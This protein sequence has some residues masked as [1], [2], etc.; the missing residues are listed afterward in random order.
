[1]KSQKTAAATSNP[2]VIKLP[3]DLGTSRS[4][5]LFAYVLD[6]NGKVIETTPFKEGSA[7]L[8][9]S[10]RKTVKGR[11]ISSGSHFP[12][13]YSGIQNRRLRDDAGGSLPSLC[14]LQQEQ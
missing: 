4:K 1:M 7:E 10:G 3:G 11:P 13:E 12:P 14:Q 8:T 5:E 6:G 2:V 9:S